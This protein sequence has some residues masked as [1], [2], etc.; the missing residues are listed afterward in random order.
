VADRGVASFAG[1][2]DR[3]RIGGWIKAFLAQAAA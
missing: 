3:I 1:S 2:D